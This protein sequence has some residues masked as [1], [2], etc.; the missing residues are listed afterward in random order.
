MAKL[1]PE[2]IRAMGSAPRATPPAPPAGVAS[3]APAAAPAPASSGRLTPDQIRAMGS[4][5]RTRSAPEQ[6]TW[7]SPLG[8]PLR[9]S[10]YDSKSGYGG[11]STGGTARL[12]GDTLKSKYPNATDR[13]MDVAVSVLGDATLADQAAAAKIGGAATVAKA[14]GSWLDKTAREYLPDELVTAVE[15]VGETRLPQALGAFDVPRAYAW[16]VAAEAGSL[17]PDDDS[18][19][20]EFL[21]NRAGDLMQAATAAANLTDWTGAMGALSA[22]TSRKLLIEAPE[23]EGDEEAYDEAIAEIGKRLYAALADGTIAKRAADHVADV[24]YGGWHPSQLTG[25]DIL[26]IALP[27]EHA[28]RLAAVATDEGD[29]AL[30]AALSTETG[31]E[32]LGIIPE[33]IVDPLW[34]SGASEASKLVTGGSKIMRA[35]SSAVADAAAAARHLGVRSAG[36]GAEAR[37]AA[38]LAD[39]EFVLMAALAR[40]AEAGTQTALPLVRT[41]VAEARRAEAAATGAGR[42]KNAARF[43][44]DARRAERLEREIVNGALGERFVPEGVLKWHVPGSEKTHYVL[45]D[46]ELEALGKV[47]DKTPWMKYMITPL[48]KR[49]DEL[50]ALRD[51]VATGAADASKMTNGDLLAWAAA[52][53]A[54]ATWEV[55]LFAW[56]TIGRMMGTRNFVTAYLPAWG[57]VAKLAEASGRPLGTGAALGL[58]RKVGRV[59]PAEV[60]RYQEAIASLVTKAAAHDQELLRATKRIFTEAARVAEHRAKARGAAGSRLGRVARAVWN[61]K[62]YDAENVVNEAFDAIERGAGQADAFLASH[63]EMAALVREARAMQDDIRATF[64]VEIEQSR[65]ALQAIA[66][67]MEGDFSR[68]DT[69]AAA[70]R[71]LSPALDAWADPAGARKQLDTFAQIAAAQKQSALGAAIESAQKALAAT[72]RPV[73]PTWSGEMRDLHAWERDLWRKFDA[74]AQRLAPGD[75][76]APM[77]AIMLLLRDEA[78]LPKDIKGAF[79]RDAAGA[80]DIAGKTKYAPPGAGTPTLALDGAERGFRQDYREL[81]GQR[82]GNAEADLEP[83]MEMVKDLVGRYEDMYRTSGETFI[84]DPYQRMKAFGVIGFVPHLL[85]GGAAVLRGKLTSA[86]SPPAPRAVSSLDKRLSTGH[87]ARRH[88]AN[89]GV[90]SE[91]N[92]EFA[93]G[94]G[95][96]FSV[97]P[98]AL[99]ARY[100]QANRAITGREFLR[101]VIG[102]GVA[103]QFAADA[104]PAD[105]VPLFQA[106]DKL[107]AYDF[108]VDGLRGRVASIAPADAAAALDAMRR[109]APLKKVD[110]F[111][112]WVTE[113]PEMRRN[114]QANQMLVEVGLDRAA[115]GLP[116]LTLPPTGASRAEFD[117]AAAALNEA[118]IDMLRR[119]EPVEGA[120]TLKTTGDWLSAFVEDGPARYYVPAALYQ[121]AVDALDVVGELAS[122]P[123]IREIK[124]AFDWVNAFVKTRLTIINTAFHARNMVW[125]AFSNSLDLGVMGALSPKTQLR[126]AKVLALFQYAGEYGSLENAATALRAA[127][128]PGEGAREYAERQAHRKFFDG[129]I[130][131]HLDEGIDLGDG[132]QR[133]ASDAMRLLEESGVVT[134][135]YTDLNDLTQ[136]TANLAELLSD[137]GPAHWWR[138]A[139]KTARKAEDWAL[140]AAT[141]TIGAAGGPLSAA[142]AAST[143][144]SKHHGEKLAG[145]IENHARLVNFIGNM[146][147]GGSWE[148]SVTHVRKYLFDYNDM[149]GFQKV[150]MRSIFQFYSWNMK[151]LLLMA[152]IAVNDPVTFA[153]LNRLLVTGTPAVLNAKEMEDA[154]LA[155]EEPPVGGFRANR[156][157]IA[158]ERLYDQEL[159]RVRIPIPGERDTYVTSLGSNVE[160][161]VEQGR[162]LAGALRGDP[163][164]MAQTSAGIRFLAE[165][166]LGV[167]RESVFGV[168][169]KGEPYSYYY[170]R[171]YNELTSGRQ[172]AQILAGVS[173]MRETALEAGMP[174]MAAAY[175]AFGEY[176]R[177]AAGIGERP[178]AQGGKVFI[179]ENAA[180]TLSNLPIRVALNNAAAYAEA[181]HAALQDDSLQDGGDGYHPVP[182]NWRVAD[183]M[184]GISLT[185]IDEQVRERGRQRARQ[186]QAEEL[187]K[188]RGITLEQEIVRAAP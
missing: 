157:P 90:I 124:G 169:N 61:G 14:A 184:L 94:K 82:L 113:V 26:D 99:I 89:A 95:R 28:A 171:P 30:Y 58:A 76:E 174:T 32:A 175:D 27:K 96:M 97:S 33:M 147:R 150:W 153:Q 73:L 112:A 72:D 63:P 21:K 7:E 105:Y 52:R 50:E 141:T 31:R 119:A 40:D 111:A 81:L 164:I 19:A 123:F 80:A 70:L 118:Y 163:R 41:A 2:Q 83:L 121:N 46:K 179:T 126:A 122:T 181:Y 131:K 15:E 127:R 117:R 176:L 91:I 69:M 107:R 68:Y 51:A 146:R 155:G 137:G 182:F 177:V 29:R 45:R 77:R 34:W 145:A 38:G 65:Q 180:F 109:G 115:Q 143:R 8:E 62:M 186:E 48:G 128:L 85:D 110:P 53:T 74:A 11:T 9:A 158:K 10:T 47:W 133:S 152:D 42:A 59:A 18:A 86:L 130:A 67:T 135:A 188:A 106:H 56:H 172:V 129:M 148:D 36:L 165:G 57:K 13:T 37:G 55:P 149:S 3:A 39:A 108:L 140:L 151:N 167:A 16:K 12:I 156:P 139:Q 154:L 160:G 1:T 142:M 60:A 49:V 6:D 102:S 84:R 24:D 178:T 162:S 22:A 170:G 144:M 71:Q 185:Q 88:R 100:Q 161:A 75:P 78:K 173:A 98:E 120:G 87:D 134:G 187:W 44:E 17:L 20:G 35:S 25:K 116:P 43:A 125:N 101:T 93:D 4:A 166:G 159:S 66:R 132:V 183:A 64:G 23:G 168:E 92:A 104:V 54:K 114:L 138:T 136:A 79:V 103:K 5:P